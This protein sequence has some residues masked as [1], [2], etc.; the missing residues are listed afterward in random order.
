MAESNADAEAEAVR[1]WY[2]DLL[3]KVV[4]EMIDIKA[5]T[6]TAVQA[7]PVWMVPNELLMAKVWGVAKEHEFVWTLSIDKLIADYV[8]GSLATSPREVARHFSMKWQLD[9]DRLLNH[10]QAKGPDDK[11]D[12]KMQEFSNKLIQYAE[13]LYDLANRDEVWEERQSFTD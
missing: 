9:A 12:K 2:T 6:G 7:S 10:P 5:V 1:T 13:V 3:D 4:K 8:S 11:P